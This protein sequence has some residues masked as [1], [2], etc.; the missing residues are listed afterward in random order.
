LPLTLTDIAPGAHT[1]RID[2]GDRHERIERTVDVKAGIVEE[3]GVVRLKVLRGQL[4]IDIVTPGATVALFQ[5]APNG[6]ETKLPVN[7]RSQQP[8]MVDVEGDGWTLVAKKTGYRTFTRAISFEDG[9]A[10]KAIKVD[11]S[12]SSEAS[13]PPAPPAPAPP[14]AGGVA[15]SQSPEPKAPPSTPA[16]VGEGTLHINSIPISKV[17]LDGKPLGNTPK[18]SV[19]VPAGTHQVTF[20]HPEM[21]KKTITVIVKP[22]ETKTA[23]VRF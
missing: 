22:G 15:G 10:E 13:A 16:P 8:V 5:T 4:A 9:I 14:P 2:A 12:S 18:V 17:L 6:I 23:V 3:L 20:I 7:D 1:V 11:L 19:T 21:G